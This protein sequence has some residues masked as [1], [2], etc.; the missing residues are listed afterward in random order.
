MGWV[1]FVGVINNFSSLF[2]SQT[3]API[4][5]KFGMELPRVEDYHY[6]HCMLMGLFYG[7]NEKNANI[8]ETIRVR[9]ILS[10]FLSHRV[11]LQSSKLDFHKNFVLPKMEAILNFQIF[12][13]NCKTQK[14]LYLENRAR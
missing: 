4:F 8:S 14:Y 3:T 12:R 5:L 1:V 13:K 2:S 6:P 7:V 9:A 10:K 11:C